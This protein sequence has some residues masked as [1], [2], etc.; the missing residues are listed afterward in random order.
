MSQQQ[1]SNAPENSS[2]SQPVVNPD[3]RERRPRQERQNQDYRAGYATEGQ[4][5][6]EK[7]YPT[8]RPRR[9]KRFRWLWIIFLVILMMGVLS[10]GFYGVNRTLGKSTTVV[11]QTFAMQNEPKLVI[12]DSLGTVNIHA[13]GSGSI[14]IAGTKHIGFFGNSND[15]QVNATRSGNNELDVTVQSNNQGLVPFNNGSVD[16]DIT[17]PSLTDIQDTSNAGSLNINGVDGQ[18]N[19]QANA[20]TINVRD[21]MLKGQSTFG[22]N[23]GSIN[24][25]GSLTPNGTYNFQANAG[26]INLT[27]PS[28]SSF[29]LDLSANAGS[30]NNDFGSD[31]VGSP[32]FAQ[33]NAHTNA[34][35]INI[36]KA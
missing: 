15:V 9:S 24:Y 32:P 35:S 20:G 5:D 17:V 27:L 10:G 28:G 14:V 3:P 11:T 26:S 4:H 23:A 6:G 13:G 22:A 2:N 1:F 25:G 36:H 8:S 33:I 30:V 12:I 18:M 16:L 29:T 34:G 7:V 19:L 31:T 21:A